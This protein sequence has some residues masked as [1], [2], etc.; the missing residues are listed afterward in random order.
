MD[1]HPALP[2]AGG[3]YS[4]SR[5]LP[6][7]MVFVAGQ[8]GVDPATRALVDGGIREQTRQAIANVSAI[9]ADEGLSRRDVVKVS[10]FLAD[11]DDFA[12]MNEVYGALFDQPYPVRTTVAAGL[13]AGAVVEID[14]VAF[15]EQAARG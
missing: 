4:L 1:A 5:R 11:S 15:D 7:G 12:A 10:V 14:V 2:Q 8:I 9:L 6:N 3:P 13:G